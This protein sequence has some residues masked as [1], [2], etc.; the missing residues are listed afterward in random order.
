MIRIFRCINAGFGGQNGYDLLVVVVANILHFD[1][2]FLAVAESF[3][4]VYEFQDISHYTPKQRFLIRTGGWVVYALVKLIGKTLRFETDG[5]DPMSSESG[6]SK[7]PILCF[8]H[9]RILSSTY[10][11]RDRGIVVMSSISFDAEYTA[12]CIQR[13]GFG[14]IKGSSTRGGTRALVE[15]I[16]MMKNGTPTAFTIDGPKGPRYQAKP[17]PALLSKRT[18]SPIVPFAVETSSFRTLGTWDKLQIPIPFSK[19]KVFFGEPIVVSSDAED[20]DLEAATATLQ[21]SLDE[22]VERGKQWRNSL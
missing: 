4:K 8:W 22:L 5:V 19:A 16:R 9:D 6:D 20:E 11:F 7:P 10:F 1:K 12:R 3:D 17:G 14:V 18:G 13:F 21:G 15:M 2:G